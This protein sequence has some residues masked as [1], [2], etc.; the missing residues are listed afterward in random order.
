MV[1]AEPAAVAFHPTL[2][3]RALP[4]RDAVPRGEPI[5][6]PE[7]LPSRRLDTIAAEQHPLHRRLQVVI[8][9]L[10]TPPMRSKAYSWPSRNAS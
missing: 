4:A 8:A 5:V 9:D 6:R 10:S 1:A 2:L 7:L 3:V